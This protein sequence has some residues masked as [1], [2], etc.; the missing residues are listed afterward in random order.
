MTHCDRIGY[1]QI[2]ACR[3][4]KLVPRS[5]AIRSGEHADQR[6]SRSATRDLQRP[7]PD[8]DRMIKRNYR[9]HV[10]RL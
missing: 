5:V 9:A 10:R 7:P 6:R 8:V 2:V 3:D 4:L 1:A